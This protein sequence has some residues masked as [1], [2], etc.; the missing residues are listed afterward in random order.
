M[1]NQVL[2]PLPHSPGVGARRKGQ[3]VLPTLP[4]SAFTP[5]NTGTSE[6][7][8]LAASPNTIHPSKVIDA[9]VA[10]PA[11]DLSKW[12]QE[13]ATVLEGKVAGVVVSLGGDDVEKYIEQYVLLFMNGTHLSSIPYIIR[14]ISLFFS[15]FFFFLTIRY[16]S[17]TSPT[18]IIAILV[19]FNLEDGIPATPPPYL[20]SSKAHQP[21][22]VLSA[23]FTKS[24]PKAIEALKWALDNGFHVDLDVQANLRDNEGEWEALEEFFSNAIS[25]SDSIPQGKVILCTSPYFLLSPHL[26]NTTELISSPFNGSNLIQFILYLYIYSEYFTPT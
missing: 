8:P 13:T 9:Q 5:P 23:I 25:R 20:T 2:P 3:R 1:S 19:P 14:I 16:S 10:T 12:K 18:P 4:L 26:P 24:T 7:F 6:Q 22:I 21:R 15:L 17:S 11:G